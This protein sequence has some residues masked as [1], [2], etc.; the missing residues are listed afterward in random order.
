MANKTYTVYWTAAAQGDLHSLV[1][2]IAIE[3]AV[4]AKKI[5]KGIKE[6]ASSL[7]TSPLRGRIIPELQYYGI[8]D[9]R[10]L[11]ASPWRIIFRVDNDKVI[12]FAV[13]DSRRNLED[14]LLE[15]LL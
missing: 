3:S 9:Y 5:Y 6:K 15:R 1:D 14:I 2:Y 7:E 12:V 8:I 4:N 10:E 13:F 11:V